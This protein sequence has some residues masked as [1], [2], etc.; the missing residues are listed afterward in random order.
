M[1]DGSNS[2]DT[3]PSSQI[4]DQNLK[5]EKIIGWGMDCGFELE[6]LINRYDHF[7]TSKNETAKEEFRK[8]LETAAQSIRPDAPETVIKNLTKFHNLYARAKG[9]IPPFH[10]QHKIPGALEN[11]NN[12]LSFIEDLIRNFLSGNL[13]DQN[14]TKEQKP[15]I[16]SL[17]AMR[18]LIDDIL[19]NMGI[20]LESLNPDELS[21]LRL[22]AAFWVI[23][24][25]ALIDY[26]FWR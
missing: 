22:Q 12:K 6:R 17:E 9:L 18:S 2:P 10:V 3:R 4:K 21:L 26:S 8:Q 5:Q 16:P 24:G 23:R 19:R 15:Y 7:I 13:T 11:A 1:S 14:A 25:A 20:Q